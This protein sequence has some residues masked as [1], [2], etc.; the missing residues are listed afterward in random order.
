M[1]ST[2]VNYRHPRHYERCSP[3]VVGSVGDVLG[4]VRL[5]H[6]APD[7]PLRFEY[8]PEQVEHHGSNVQNGDMLNYE[9]NGYYKINDSNWGGGRDMKTA[10]G[11]RHQDLRAPDKRYEPTA[12]FSFS[13]FDNL[14]HKV[15]EARR[16]GDKFLPVTNGYAPEAGSVPRGGLVPIVNAIAGGDFTPQPNSV[17]TNPVTTYNP[18]DIRR[19]LPGVRGAYDPYKFT[20]DPEPGLRT[21]KP[22]VG[23]MG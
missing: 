8:S 5:K 11:W 20:T 15:F 6:S 17:V 12:S 23:R 22:V 7:L 4:Q 18:T 1:T 3:G 13:S 14:Q 2:I 19:S 10:I 16:T 9:G 21:A